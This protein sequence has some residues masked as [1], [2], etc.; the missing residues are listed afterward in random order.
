MGGTYEIGLPTSITMPFPP[1][2]RFK[3]LHGALS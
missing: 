3:R 1:Y 2:G